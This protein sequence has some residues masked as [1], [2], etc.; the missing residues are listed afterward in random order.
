MEYSIIWSAPLLTLFNFLRHNK[1][2]D[3]IELI[4]LFNYD[5]KVACENNNYACILH[6]FVIRDILPDDTVIT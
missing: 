2:G 3:E 6:F 1:C 5:Y 4:D